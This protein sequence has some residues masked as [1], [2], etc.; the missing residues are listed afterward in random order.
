[1][2]TSPNRHDL[3]EEAKRLAGE[4]GAAM[5][6]VGFTDRWDNERNRKEASAARTALLDAI[7]KLAAA[8]HPQDLTTL[9]WCGHC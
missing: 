6:S 7:D 9:R 1:M 3:A 2:T 8:A 5:R 4:Y